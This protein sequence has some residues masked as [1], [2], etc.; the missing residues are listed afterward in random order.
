MIITKWDSL[1]DAW[2][3]QRHWLT[4]LL[5]SSPAARKRPCQV[6]SGYKALT[7]WHLNL[8]YSMLWRCL[9]GSLPAPH[10]IEVMIKHPITV[11]AGAANQQ[12]RVIKGHRKSSFRPSERLG[13]IR[14]R[15]PG[16]TEARVQSSS[17][18][19]AGRSKGRRQ[20]AAARRCVERP[21]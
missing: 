19:H 21:V 2:A 15:A 12:H 5:R 18:K 20:A 13:R 4:P 17:R 8:R 1:I 3:A 6:A 11:A 9:A 10:Q 14:A 7:P 16:S